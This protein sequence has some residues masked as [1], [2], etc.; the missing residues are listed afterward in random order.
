MGEVIWIEIGSI[1]EII[2]EAFFA[3][4]EDIEKILE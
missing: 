1:L 2:M 3:A 4:N